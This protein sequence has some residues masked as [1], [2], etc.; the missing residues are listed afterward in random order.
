MFVRLLQITDIAHHKCTRTILE[1]LTN[2]LTR[3][4]LKKPARITGFHLPAA[5][6]AT[7][8]AC[9]SST[10]PA[11]LSVSTNKHKGK[12]KM[13]QAKHSKLDYL[14]SLKKAYRAATR[15]AKT[16]LLD[17][18]IRLTGYNRHYAARLLRSHHNLLKPKTPAPR[19]RKRVY[20]SAV[21][22]VVL[23]VRK[24]QFGACAELV[25]PILVERTR[26]LVA[27]GELSQPSEDTM[28]KLAR[29]SVSTVKRMFQADHDRSYDKLKLHG[30]T[31]TPGKLLKPM[32]AVRVSFW[33]ETTPGFYETDTVAHNG[34]DPNGTFIFSLNMTDVL[35]G[36]TEPE[37]IMGKGERACV[38]AIDDIRS[39]VPVVFKGIDSDGGS[40]FI[41]WHLF[42]YCERGKIDFTRSRSGQKNDNAHVEQKNRVVIR[43]LVGHVR[44]DTNE[45]LVI[46]NQL[47]RGPWRKYYNYFLPT[48]KVVKRSYDKS[49]GKARFTY[50]EARTPYQRIVD[51]PEVPATVKARLQAEYATLNP[52]DLM[53]DIMLL[54]NKLM[55]TIQDDAMLSETAPVKSKVEGDS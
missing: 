21:M 51:H 3:K 47:Y 5:P 11:M 15:P 32:V 36:W 13:L 24:V 35:S 34:G 52:A 53:R 45:Q 44:Y 10:S 1:W 7:A 26:Q 29:I 31:T 55:A 37:A 54:R 25:Q 49:S 18:A 38:A 4:Q 20:D 2:N 9:Q 6:A 41:N 42:R 40:E 33:D 28:A 23:A 43:E 8:P 39:T 30:G 48:R 50:D 12:K 46:L 27:F 17:I 16:S 19:K 22:A 14:Q